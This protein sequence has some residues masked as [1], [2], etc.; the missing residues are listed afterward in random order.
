MPTCPVF[1]RAKIKSHFGILVQFAVTK[2]RKT[3]PEYIL[4]LV[5]FVL[6]LWRINHCTA[7]GN[8]YIVIHRQTVSFYQN[9]SV[10]LDTQDARSR[11]RNPSNFTLACVSDHSATKWTTLAKGILKYFY[12]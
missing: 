2:Q 6:I 8:I 12:F 3:N 7:D 4:D 10:W 9:F 11:D 5:F 1:T